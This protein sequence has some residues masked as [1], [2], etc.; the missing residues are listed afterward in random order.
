MLSIKQFVPV[1]S[2]C[3]L[4]SGCYVVPIQ[5]YANSNASSNPAYS[6]AAPVVVVPRPIYT[7][8]LYPTN[9]T[10]SAMGR[11]T[12]TISN[13]EKGHG[14]FSFTVGGESFSGEATREPGSSK[15]KANAAGNR[16]GF[17]Q[18][19]YAMT[20]SALG[21]GSCSFSSGARYDMHVSL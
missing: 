14:E 9:D 11:I 19:E 12:G 13:P 7:A 10:A 5:P 20:S 16:G 15:G 6:Q 2:L 4:L 18:C 3:A 17:A 8:R 21:T 1:G